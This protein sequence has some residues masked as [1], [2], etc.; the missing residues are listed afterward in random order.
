MAWNE[1]AYLIISL[2]RLHIKHPLI[3][4]TL[5]LDHLS[6]MDS[7]TEQ[8]KVHKLSEAKL[9]R[10]VILDSLLVVDKEECSADHVH[11]ESYHEVSQENVSHEKEE[12]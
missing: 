1:I 6:V 3:V 10:L 12:T 5:P 11:T 8:E 7:H 9:D 2:R 4:K